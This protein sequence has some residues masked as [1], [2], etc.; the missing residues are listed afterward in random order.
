MGRQRNPFER[1]RVPFGGV[2]EDIKERY[3]QYL[4]DIKVAIN[5]WR[6]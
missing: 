1:T 4:S 2:I 5:V 6:T 3:P